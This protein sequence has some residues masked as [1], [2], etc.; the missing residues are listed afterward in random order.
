MTA[1]TLTPNTSVT[2]AECPRTDHPDTP[3][4]ERAV[5]V[6]LIDEDRSWM[7]CWPCVIGLLAE[8]QAGGDKFTIVFDGA[9]AG[10]R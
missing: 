1:P 9:L 3:D 5:I 4:H 2:C 10:G 7:A 6:P 8:M